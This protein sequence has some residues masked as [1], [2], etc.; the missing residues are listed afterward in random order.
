[1][2]LLTLESFT[3][4]GDLLRYLRQRERLTQ[5]DLG[6]AVG[7]G[8]AQINRLE[9]G[10]RLP[11][12]GLVV[13]Q[14]IPA[15]HLDV[16]P[17]IAVRLVELAAQARGEPVPA[18]FTFTR[19]T[20]LEFTEEI[21]FTP[22][23][24]RSNLP[25]QVTSFVGREDEIAELVERVK[26][27][28]L[29]TLT[30]SG[31]CSKTRLSLEVASYV[32]D[33]FPDGV[34]LIEFA[35]SADES[36]VPRTVASLFSPPD[37]TGTPPIETLVNY[38]ASKRQLLVLDNCEH[39]IN[40]C[41]QLAE[42]LVRDCPDIHLLATSREPLRIEGEV[43]WRVPS[44]PQDESVQLFVERAR[45]IRPDFDLTDGN[46]PAI[47]SICGHLDG[48]PLAIELAAA[49]LNALT[50][51]Q[52]AE[53][54]SDRFALLVSRNRT[55][56]PRHQTLHATIGWSFDLLPAIERELL[57]QLS[58]FV[59]GFTAEAAE[60][61]SDHPDAFDLLSNLVDK[62]LVIAEVE[63]NAVCY[64]MLEMVR[65]FT[66]GHLRQ[67]G[68]E[69]ATRD[70]HLDYCIELAE[71]AEIDMRG[72]KDQ[73][74]LKRLVPEHDNVR[75]ALAWGYDSGK[76]E[77][78]L[79]LAGALWRFWFTQAHLREGL[80]W[81]GKLLGANPDPPAPMRAKALYGAAMMEWRTGDWPRMAALAGESL[82]LCRELDDPIGAAISLI[83]LAIFAQHQ[84]NFQQAR[85]M[86][87]EAISLL[88]SAQHLW[89]LSF[90]FTRLGE[91]LILQG[92]FAQAEVVMEECLLLS[93]ELDLLFALD[94][95][96]WK[97]RAALAQDD[98][99]NAQRLAQ[100][101]LALAQERGQTDILVWTF[102]FL[103]HIALQ[104]GDYGQ[105]TV[106]FERSQALWQEI[107]YGMARTG[108]ILIDLGT[109]ARLQG[110]HET[111][112]QRYNEAAAVNREIGEF[113]GL[114]F[115]ESHLGYAM[116]AQGHESRAFMHFRESVKLA[117]KV[118]DKTRLAVGL[119]AVAGMLQVRSDVQRAVRLCAFASNFQHLV[120]ATLMP[121]ER[122]GYE[123]TLAATRAKLDDPFLASAWAEGRQMTLEEAVT[124]ALEK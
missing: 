50:P 3:T 78:S 104:A 119:A 12:V 122:M 24:R 93:R 27:T 53:R 84:L 20:R 89:G 120:R 82:S 28:R 25:A 41:A 10:L 71:T 79:R 124:L 45:A 32:Q 66:T 64:R 11:D 121:V 67:A 88:R 49:R 39:L 68:R 33:E 112:I 43:H 51:E 115:V 31:G 83:C 101:R 103:G 100:H 44:L 26:T 99:L 118:N 13:A 86:L 81:I 23:T 105:A 15:L 72:V 92:E 46:A 47:T 87:E 38:L 107:N 85:T 106:F 4:F 61:V 69:D 14:F 91:L 75:A 8:Q 21:G 17:D 123:R 18:S 29:L 54:L 80:A 73:P 5:R 110:D 63:G 6:Q 98:F 22:R 34:W 111:A 56:I 117:C 58:V 108:L 90:A 40:G 1:M 60:A 62:S 19:S 70:R 114:A 109:V 95:L 116:L 55:A 77:S 7:Y 52:I 96:S 9:N 48:I 59:G 30:G 42:R 37:T 65:Q 76:V 102:R 57:C 97:I 113:A 35:P 94:V 16:Q 36:F 74:A 2:K